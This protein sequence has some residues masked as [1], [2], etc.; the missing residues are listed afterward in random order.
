L[1]VSVAVIHSAAAQAVPLAGPVR[2]SAG[3]DSSAG[4]SWYFEYDPDLM[5]ADFVPSQRH[6]E[7][8]VAK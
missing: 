5:M 2:L 8:T 7:V 4:S 1:A 3:D 6:R